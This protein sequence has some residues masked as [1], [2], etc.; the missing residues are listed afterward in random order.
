MNGWMSESM[1]QWTD[2]WT[3]RWT[4]THMDERKERKTEGRK[5]L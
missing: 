5:D 2:G 1:G 4:C 3:D